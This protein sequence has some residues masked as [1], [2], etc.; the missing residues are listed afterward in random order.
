MLPKDLSDKEVERL[1]RTARTYP[2]GKIPV[3][4]DPNNFVFHSNTGLTLMLTVDSSTGQPDY[5]FSMS[6]PRRAPT[7]DE[8]RELLKKFFG[9]DGA[10][11]ARKVV[12]PEGS[13]TN[14]V[15]YRVALES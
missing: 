14:V 9:E 15:H 12:K 3:G 4:F 1:K 13:S 6:Y 2:A 7:E 11:K 10:A 8:A 5:H